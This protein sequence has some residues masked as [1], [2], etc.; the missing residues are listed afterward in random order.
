[1]VLRRSPARVR[2]SLRGSP[3]REAV[4][5]AGARH[6]ICRLRGLAEGL[7]ARRGPRSPARLLARQARRRSARPR[8]SDRSSATAAA[9]SRRSASVLHDRQACRRP[10]GGPRTRGRRDAVHDAARGVSASLVALQRAARHQ[11]RRAGRQSP[12]SRARAADRLLREHAGDAHRSVRRSELP[13]PA[14]AGSRDR[15]LGAQ[16]HQD[17]PF[18]RLVEDLRGRSAT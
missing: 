15:A 5:F 11:R 16:A 13:R 17:L 4:A 18:E 6:S 2:R 7:A 10:I 14:G 1:M 8:S 12:S 3:R 9:G